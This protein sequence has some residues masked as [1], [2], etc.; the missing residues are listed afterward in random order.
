MRK[1]LPETLALVC[2]PLIASLV[3]VAATASGDGATSAAPPLGRAC[4]LVPFARIYELFGQAVAEVT[5]SRGA[6]QSVCT[7]QFASGVTFTLRY[8]KPGGPW[9][10]KDGHDFDAVERAFLAH[11]SPGSIEESGDVGCFNSPITGKL[12]TQYLTTCGNTSGYVS[13][14][15]VTTT[16]AVPIATARGLLADAMQRI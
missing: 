5:P 12:G 13:L 15:I 14:S 11:G 4:E 8:A 9:D 2:A 16:S 7:I 1:N 3:A 6:D 10:P